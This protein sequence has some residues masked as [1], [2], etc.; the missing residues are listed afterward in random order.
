MISIKPFFAKNK[1]FTLIELLVVVSVIG[2]LATLLLSSMKSSQQRARDVQRKSNLLAIK[3]ALTQYYIDYKVFPGS[4]AG[5]VSGCGINGT[6]AC[7]W[8]GQWC[9]GGAGGCSKI[10]MSLLPVDA[11]NVSPYLYVY[12]FLTSDSFRLTAEL[13]NVNDADASISRTKCGYTCSG[14]CN[15]YV[16][17]QD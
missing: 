12:T 11:L 3:T 16:V 6:N 2:I 17:C 10:Y 5:R 8:G 9:A 1:G 4:S 13:E 7:N 14:T 15:T